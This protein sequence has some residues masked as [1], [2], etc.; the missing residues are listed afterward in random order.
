[1]LQMGMY[2]ASTYAGEV[3]GRC[4]IVMSSGSIL[5]TKISEWSF[6]C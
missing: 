2:Q 3:A 6:L 5:D 1:M 4:L